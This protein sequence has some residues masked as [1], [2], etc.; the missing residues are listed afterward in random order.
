MS[1]LSL[2]AGRAL[3]LYLAV[4]K[5]E[6]VLLL[7]DSSTSDIADA[8]VAAGGSLSLDISK[9]EML[10]TGG[11]G[12]EPPDKIA[13]M[14]KTF[15]VV[16]APTMYSITHTDAVRES[17]RCGARVATLPGV[18][19]ETFVNG[20]AAE[21][22]DLDSAGAHWTERLTGK[23]KIRVLAPG[24]TDIEFEV[25]RHKP[26]NDNGRIDRGG[27][28]GNLPAGEAFVAPDEL[29]AKGLLVIDGTI[30]GQRGPD[31]TSPVPLEIKGGRI[32]EFLDARACAEG[33]QRL[34]KL[35][36]TLCAFGDEA[37]LLAEFGIGTNTALKMT[38]NLLGDEKIAGTVHFAFGNNCSMGG[39]NNV[40]VHIDCLVRDPQIYVDGSR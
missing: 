39:S 5:G 32:V 4:G 35:K 24:G 3:G 29:S 9:V 36:D 38:G 37:L 19:A 30:G 11:H 14:M 25:G 10:P 12:K 34:A 2:S 7:Y 15:D 27:I 1:D 21:P 6:R 33:R 17:I 26:L 13:Q 16:I 20:L 28:F 23:R 8:F 22:E 18:D 40:K 31:L